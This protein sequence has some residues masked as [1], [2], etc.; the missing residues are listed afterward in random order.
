MWRNQREENKSDSTSQLEIT[1]LLPCEFTM[2]DCKCQN[3]KYFSAYLK[4][5]QSVDRTKFDQD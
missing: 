2:E 4:L 1:H 5:S 3:K